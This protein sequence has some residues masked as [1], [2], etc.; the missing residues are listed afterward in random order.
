MVAVLSSP[1]P[2]VAV[3]GSCDGAGRTG[4]KFGEEWGRQGV[5]FC[6]LCVDP[7]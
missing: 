5:E 7:P 4:Q 1:P 6:G 3:G 2:T